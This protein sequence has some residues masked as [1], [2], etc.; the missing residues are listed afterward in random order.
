MGAYDPGAVFSPIDRIGR[1]A[2]ANYPRVATWNLARLA[3][4]LW[5]VGG[6]W[7]IRRPRHLAYSVC[8]D[9]PDTI[10]AP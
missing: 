1:Y 10:R 8:C 3:E 9:P 7:W 2:Y 4:T 5:L 6:A